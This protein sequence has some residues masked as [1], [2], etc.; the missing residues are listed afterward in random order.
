MFYTYAH[1][2]STGR[3]FY[4]GKGSGSRAQAKDSRNKYWYNVVKKYGNPVI[5]IL[6]NWETEEE[7]FKHEIVLI[8]CFRD[9][10][11]KLANLT[12]GGEGSSGYKHTEEQREKNRQAKLGSIPWN[13]GMPITEETRKR[14]SKALTGKIAWNKGIPLR[15]ETKQKLREK[16]TGKP[17]HTEEFKERIRK[18]HTGNKYSLGKPASTKQ[19]AVA[20]A[21]FKGNT[22]A[23]GNTVQRK[24]IWV[25]T[26]IETG[27]V[28]R[29]VGEKDMKQNS[30]QYAN[31]IKCIKGERKSHK[32]YTWAKEPWS[33][34]V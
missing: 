15:E 18:I 13:K 19:K 17:I 24:W 30:F 5:Q 26:H 22:Y 21:L 10:G 25:G 31:I 23:T 6:A 12:N 3:L 2:T 9:M 14:L 34:K 32:G 1:Y 11:Y 29:I 20:S 8:N 27:N 16:S 7:S 28:I 33:N 4:I